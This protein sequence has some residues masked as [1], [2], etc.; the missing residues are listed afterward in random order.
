MTEADEGR[1]NDPGRGERDYRRDSAGCA[2]ALSRFA[3]EIT[4]RCYLNAFK[5]TAVTKPSD[6]AGVRRRRVDTTVYKEM[7]NVSV[8]HSLS[9]G[10]P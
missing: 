10:E 6:A 3:V 2:G 5:V 9:S 8:H 1:L 4:F 7:L